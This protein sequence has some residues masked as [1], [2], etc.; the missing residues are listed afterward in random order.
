M[1]D[2]HKRYGIEQKPVHFD[3][4]EMKVNL[5]KGNFIFVG[6]S[7]DLFAMDVDFL[8]VS[9]V[10]ARC[11]FFDNQYLFQTKNPGNLYQYGFYDLFPAKSIFCVTME[12]NRHISGIMGQAPSPKARAETLSSLDIENKMITVEP[13]MDFDLEEFVRM[14]RMCHPDQVNI[15]A[16]SGHNH[17]PEPSTEKIEALINALKPP[18]IVHLKD[19]LSRIY[20]KGGRV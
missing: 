10:L 7:C 15:G 3:T 19:N 17:L 6:S 12:T 16:D 11:N 13:I 9:A 5:G 8:D 2:I 18:I 20:K 1:K 4:R 14:I